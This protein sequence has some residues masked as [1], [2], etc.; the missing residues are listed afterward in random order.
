MSTLVTPCSVCKQPI[1]QE[2]LDTLPNTQICVSCA[3]VHVSQDVAYMDYS[4]KTAPMLVRIKGGDKES[5][6]RAQRAFRR[7]R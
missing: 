3:R 4:H 6:R 5:L 7:A 2:R 1:S